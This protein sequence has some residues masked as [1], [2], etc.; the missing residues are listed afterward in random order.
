MSSIVVLDIETT[1]L[2]PRRD[3]IIEIGAVRF[4]SRRVED[5]WT[6][7]VNPGRELPAFITRLT[8]ITTGMLQGAP[9][10]ATVMP[11]LQEF[12]AD[13]P[14]LGHNVNF[15]VSFF[16][17][18][19][20][21]EYN[22]LLD[23]Y[24]L[25][26]VLL[27]GAGRYN[28]G[29]LAQHLGIPMP[30]AHRAMED[31]RITMQVFNRLQEKALE[32]PLDI[33]AEIVR[34]GED[35]PWGADHVFRDALKARGREQA[36]LGKHGRAFHGPLFESP[37]PPE[38]EPLQP[39]EVMRPLDIEEVASFLEHGGPFSKLFEQFEHRPEQVEL[40]RAIATALSE[41][42]HL[43]AEA[44]TGVGK[45][46]AYLVP[47]AA[48]ALLNNARV[49]ISTNTL[50]LQDQLINKDIPSLMQVVGDGLNA[51]VLKGRNN[52]LCPRRLDAL[53][54]KKPETA[55]EM[56]VLAK[57]LIWL[58]EDGGGDLSEINITG[59]GERAVWNRISAND[60][61]CTTETC[62]RRMGGICPFHRARQ[63]AQNAHLIVVNHALLLADVST[64]NRVLPDFRHLIVD[65]AH[66]M[67]AA[68]TNALS[69]KVNQIDVER[70]LRELGGPNAGYLGRVLVVAQEVLDPG[71]LAALNELV[72]RA[73]DKAFQFQNAV[74]GFFV[75]LDHF[76][77]EQR[78]GR[79]LG[80]YSHQERIV[81]ATRTQP[82][83]L[84]I[85]TAWDDA[86]NSLS[87]LLQALEQVNQALSEMAE[88]G[89]EEIEDLL[90]NIQNVYRR[91]AEY[92][93]NLNATVFEPSPE[94]VYWAEVDPQRRLV[95]LQA[96]PL[97]IGSL[98][99]K[100]LWHE[101][102]SITLTSATLTAGG[103]FGYIRNRLWAW[104]AEEL[105]LG[106]PYDY[107]SSTLLYVPNNIPEPS[108]RRG[109]QHAVENGL[110]QLCAATGGRAL[111]LF[112]SY[113][114]LQA[115]AR[116]ISAPLSDRGILVYEQGQGASA[117]S[118]LENFRS[119][120]Q[121]VLLGTRAFWEG[122]DIP[123]EALSVLAIVKLPFAVPSDPI[124]AARSE[125]FD[126]PFYEYSLPEA[127]LT[128]R[129]GF[130]RLI[131][132]QFDRGVVAIFDRRIL[133]KQYG[134][135]FIESLPVCTFRAGRMEDLPRAA[136]EWLGL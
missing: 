127:I 112:T 109:H 87:P 107:E 64:G 18:Q 68:T 76:L 70:T 21:F 103:E 121:A 35:L 55:E 72:Q 4:N 101:K 79:Q 59:P 34:L 135:M 6:T 42:R 60:E 22:D 3:A 84:N 105:S 61:T 123:G 80:S 17:A 23:T 106:S 71:Q 62:Q 7:L 33:L 32:L 75:A 25:A 20:F 102:D 86:R 81:P 9:R 27:P 100:H 126:E 39:R 2:D 63:A 66:H 130:G 31:S 116:A 48:W 91:L 46:L 74:K 122:V 117:S 12:V 110:I 28:L 24:D 1:G 133:T 16:R 88:S 29:A 128:F 69:F 124:V 54:R 95:T 82:S 65:E 14:I 136:S 90:S 78:D 131:R 98:M 113:A 11:E 85:E 114:Q 13:L 41:G 43:L 108:D 104:D 89:I 38:K 51:A 40:S 96:A 26:S 67:E 120:E 97:H 52:Y 92:D 99:E 94:A 115:T 73:T 77:E 93:A 83:W 15:D 58:N 5:E 10:L 37:P 30:T 45:S 119:S 49:V 111:V 47:A 118:L 56:R 36:S 8:G 129:Q 50:N 134:R 44:G 125:S 19:G 57:M 132:T 53:R